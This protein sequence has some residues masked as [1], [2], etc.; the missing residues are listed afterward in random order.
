MGRELF[1]T[2]G[3]RGVANRAPMTADLALRVGAAVGVRLR[4]QLGEADERSL[5]AH[6]VLLRS[7][8]D[9]HGVGGLGTADGKGRGWCDRDTARSSLVGEVLGAPWFGESE[10]QVGALRVDPGCYVIAQVL[11]RHGLAFVRLAAS[12]GQDGLSGAIVE[13]VQGQIGRD[14]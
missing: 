2:D 12:F 1:G 14:R 7:E 4:E 6:S 8:A 9:A 3:I 5:Q 10:P 13:Q 11:A